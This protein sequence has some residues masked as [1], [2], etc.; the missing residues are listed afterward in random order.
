L[1]YED[2]ASGDWQIFVLSLKSA[3]KRLL[4]ARQGRNLFQARF[5]P[6]ER[7]LSF[8][9]DGGSRTRLWV[10]PVPANGSAE[11]A[12]WIPITSGDSFEDKPRWS[13]DGRLLYFLS[14]RDDSRCIWAQRLDRASRRPVGAAFAVYHIHGASLSMKNVMTQTTGFDVARDQLIFNMGLRAGNIWSTTLDPKQ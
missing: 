2:S 3:G 7:W 10:A 4:A 11:A 9:E 6:D 1:L 5:S 8:L 13:P 14:D 12:S